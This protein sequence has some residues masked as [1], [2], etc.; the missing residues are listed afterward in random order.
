MD[1]EGVLFSFGGHP[2]QLLEANGS[3]EI[4]HVNVWKEEEGGK[5]RE[6]YVWIVGV[7]VLRQR[8]CCCV[9]KRGSWCVSDQRCLKRRGNHYFLGRLL[10]RPGWWQSSHRL[11]M[12]I[13]SFRSH[14]PHPSRL[15]IA[16]TN[17]HSLPDRVLRQG[18][19]FSVS[20]GGQVGHPPP[21]P[22]PHH[23][24]HNSHHRI[25]IITKA[26]VEN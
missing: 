12:V 25:A 8:F 6:D 10:L 24:H 5:S 21:P 11:E 15:L 7:E 4:E 14:T 18:N 16:M 26:L 17:R 19:P 3:A 1:K 13:R 23:H 2:A 22:P 9:R 20:P